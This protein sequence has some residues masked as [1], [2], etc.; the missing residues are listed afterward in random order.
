MAA[1][2]SDQSLT[3]EGAALSGRVGEEA[4]V[5]GRNYPESTAAAPTICHRLYNSGA[6]CA[7]EE[8]QDGAQRVFIRIINVFDYKCENKGLL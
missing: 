5:T 3:G 2:L 8:G 6:T 7:G 1:A 4:D